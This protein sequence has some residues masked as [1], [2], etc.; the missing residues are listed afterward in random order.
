MK[1]T[2]NAIRAIPLKKGNHYQ[3]SSSDPL[4]KSKQWKNTK[5]I[6]NKEANMFQAKYDIRLNLITLR[7]N[8]RKFI[9]AEL[10]YESDEQLKELRENHRNTHVFMRSGNFIQC[11]PIEDSILSF[12]KEKEY[13]VLKH[14]TLANRL[15]H[16]AL[17]RFLNSKNYEFSSIFPTIR[18]I[19]KKENM[20]MNIIGDDYDD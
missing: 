16:Q 12:G 2:R 20:L 3:V 10:P 8:Q 19:I 18:I 7:F 1:S 6:E 15:V 5:L 14:F 4:G 13:D 17:I 9:G 11:I